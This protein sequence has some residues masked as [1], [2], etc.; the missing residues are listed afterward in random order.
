[1]TKH[2]G[3]TVENALR[4]L[5]GVTNA[6]ASFAQSYATVTARIGINQTRE[7]LDEAA[8]D[9]VDCVGFEARLIPDDQL[10]RYQS[11]SQQQHTVHLRVTGM[12]CQK[13]CGKCYLYQT[14]PLGD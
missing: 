2:V 4:T 8:L 6:K 9:V 10:H 3:T 14:H 13:N 12:M 1:M 5:P 7:Q 11:P